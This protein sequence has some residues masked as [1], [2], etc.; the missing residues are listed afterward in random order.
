M[1]YGPLYALLLRFTIGALCFTV[2]A[3]RLM[4]E[5]SARYQIQ[6]VGTANAAK[7][8]PNSAS[9]AT[10]AGQAWQANTL[11]SV[12]VHT[13]FSIARYRK[14]EKFSHWPSLL[15]TEIGFMWDAEN[16]SPE[17]RVLSPES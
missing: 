11:N 15:F 7:T 8:Q 2:P 14:R 3:S 10:K 4:L 9:T 12:W 1:I 13:I 5:S 17:S 16:L 6:S